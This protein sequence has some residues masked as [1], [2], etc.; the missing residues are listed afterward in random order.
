MTGC[1]PVHS[2]AAR[3]LLISA[4]G[5]HGQVRR[6]ISCEQATSFEAQN[7]QQCVVELEQT[8]A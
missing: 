5:E 7:T 4:S 8:R 6:L 2:L 3:T 1:R